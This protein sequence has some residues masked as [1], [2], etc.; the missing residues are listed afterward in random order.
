MRKLLLLGLVIF[1]CTY[2]KAQV[3]V[4]LIKDTLTVGISVATLKKTYPPMWGKEG[5]FQGREKVLMDTLK[6]YPGSASRL[7][8]VLAKNEGQIGLKNFTIFI[9]EFVKADG[10]YDWIVCSVLAKAISK[11]QEKVI[12]DLLESYY[13]N[14]PFPLKSEKGFH[15]FNSISYGG[16]FAKRTV[17]KGP[18]IISSLEDAR[19]TTRPD[20]VKILLFNQLELT[21]VPGE[22]YQFPNLEELD[23]SKNAIRHLPI[24]LTARISTL[25]RLSLLYNSL[26]PDSIFFARNKHLLALNMQGNNLKDIPDAVRRNRRLASLWMGNNKLEGGLPNRSLRGLRYLVDL[27]FYNTGLPELPRRIGRLKRLQVLDVYYNN[28]TA[29]PSSLGKLK[30]LEQLA[31]SNNKLMELPTSVGQLR[32]L[33][34]LYA[35]HN[36]LSRLPESYKKLHNLR[37]LD[38]GYNWFSQFPA[39]LPT[40]TTLEEVDLSSNNLNVLSDELIKLKNLKKLFLRQNPCTRDK[41]NL[42]DYADLIGRLQANN[43]EVF[44]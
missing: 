12:V 3:K 17:R 7:H 10:Q 6:K 1:T 9:D 31:L 8:N 25:K 39:V 22:V 2:T 11:E 30:R 42:N 33:Q 21:S 24:A 23:L 35:H 16:G 40:L 37:V 14:N 26:Q 20:T 41:N 15:Q 4:V 28:L 44:Y 34:I 32:N 29:L 18:G 13:K 43:T 38:L 19:K 36:Q 5:A 27:N